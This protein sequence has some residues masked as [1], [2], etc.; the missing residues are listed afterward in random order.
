VATFDASVPDE[1]ANDATE[2]GVYLFI[3]LFVF[4]W[5]LRMMKRKDGAGRGLRMGGGCI[6]NSSS[7]R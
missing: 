3:C 7:G 2:I 6:R 4:F 1:Y 5:N